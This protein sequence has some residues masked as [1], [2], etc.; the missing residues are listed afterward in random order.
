M[1]TL[2]W[3]L[4][5]MSLLATSVLAVAP[6]VGVYSDVGGTNCHLSDSAVEVVSYY[7]VI[8]EWDDLARASFAAPMPSCMVGAEWLFD[9]HPFSM[10]MGDSQ[11][12]VAIE[13]SGC[14]DSPLHVLTITYLVSGETPS[15]CCY[16]IIPA[17]DHPAGIIDVQDCNMDLEPPAR[18]S[19]ALINASEQCPDCTYCGAVLTESM[20]WGEIKALF[21][22]D[23]E[24]WR[25]E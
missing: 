22:E 17:P 10:H 16:P 1:K 8:T 25:G 18:S 12:G 23:N 21:E 9:T 13:F 4:L 7:V 6:V 14:L 3:L 19:P 11:S 2:T 15:C 5:L 20:T 24:L